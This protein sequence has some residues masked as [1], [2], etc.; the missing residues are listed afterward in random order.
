M[1]WGLKIR[2]FIFQSCDISLIYLLPYIELEIL[3]KLCMLY[4]DFL[5]VIR[6]SYSYSKTS[7]L[8]SE[9]RS[10]HSSKRFAESAVK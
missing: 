6:M 9:F 4:N 2:I 7:P 10:I 5:N 3:C 8:P 1:K